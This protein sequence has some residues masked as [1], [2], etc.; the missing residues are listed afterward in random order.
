M[1]CEQCIGRTERRFISH[2]VIQYQAE[3]KA[4]AAQY[5]DGDDGEF[6]SCHVG[7]TGGR[8]KQNLVQKA[9]QSDETDGRKCGA[10]TDDR[11]YQRNGDDLVKG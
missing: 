8:D 7:A 2:A 5:Q 10:Q 4:A 3:N 9:H 1:N 6:A 11:P